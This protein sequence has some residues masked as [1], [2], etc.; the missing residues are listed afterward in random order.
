MTP[1]EKDFVMK[2]SD[3]D[4]I[5]RLQTAVRVS[6]YNNVKKRN[7]WTT[8]VL[9]SRALPACIVVHQTEK[10]AGQAN[11]GGKTQN[12]WTLPNYS[13]TDSSPASHTV[14]IVP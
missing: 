6:F 3:S 4:V 1:T 11:T 8:N 5:E 7:F 14:I 9:T 10:A 2:R 12:A 13:K